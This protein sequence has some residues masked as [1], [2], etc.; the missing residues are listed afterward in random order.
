[1]VHFCFVHDCSL[2]LVVQVRA[3]CS[4]VPCAG[5]VSKGV[6]EAQVLTAVAPPLAQLLAFVQA[7][8][9]EELRGLIHSMVLA[10]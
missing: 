1:M 6:P 7:Q 3:R 9:K 2:V 5:G 10:F 8:D 4:S